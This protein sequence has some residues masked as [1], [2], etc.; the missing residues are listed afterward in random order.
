MKYEKTVTPT[1]SVKAMNILSMLLFGW[2]SP[3]PTVV[4]DVAA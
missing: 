2:K 4:N 1:R 3:N